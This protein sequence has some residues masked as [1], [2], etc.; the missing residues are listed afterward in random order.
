MDNAPA[1]DAPLESV[2][3]AGDVHLDRRDVATVAAAL[4]PTDRDYRHYLGIVADLRD[5]GWDTEHQVAASPFVVEDPAFTAIAARA[6]SDLAEVAPALHEDPAPLTD[7]A[8]SARAGLAALW[9]DDTGWYRPFDL[10]AATAI[11]PLTA[12]GL[13][14]CWAIARE[15]DEHEL[16]RVA[17]ML[18]RLDTWHDVVPGSVP[19]CDPDAAEF[20]PA[21]YWR[22]PVWVLVNW[23]VADG[24]ARSCARPRASSSSAAASASTTTRARVRGSAAT[25]SRGRPR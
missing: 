2:P 9:D 4:R 5:A 7:L 21:R 12:G 3:S 6:S 10:R 17:R 18:T 22:G 19:T 20:D 15:P 16:A 14:A 23:L 13:V 11:G 1:W 24:L 25:G 8:S